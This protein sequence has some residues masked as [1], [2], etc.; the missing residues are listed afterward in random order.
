MQCNELVEYDDILTFSSVLV[1]IDIPNSAHRDIR[2]YLFLNNLL[3]NDPPGL[4]YLKEHWKKC[5]RAGSI[6]FQ[7][8]S[9]HFF[10]S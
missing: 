1:L 3:K 6:V 8:D 9:N 2:W 10:A 7:P 4:S 5:E